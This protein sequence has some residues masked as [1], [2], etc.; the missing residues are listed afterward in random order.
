MP[1]NGGRWHADITAQRGLLSLE[2][3]AGEQSEQP[4][5]H[6]GHPKGEFL[7]LGRTAQ[8]QRQNMP[9]GLFD[10]FRAC[11]IVPLGVRATFPPKPACSDQRDQQTRGPAA[12]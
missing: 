10:V 6:R 2:R 5:L 7:V 4:T 11:G 3:G 9:Q 12:L 8:R 1:A